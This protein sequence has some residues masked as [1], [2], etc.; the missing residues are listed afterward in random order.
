MV[1]RMPCL[2]VNGNTP[3]EGMAYGVKITE[4]MGNRWDVTKTTV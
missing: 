2:N 3:D 1:P 4:R